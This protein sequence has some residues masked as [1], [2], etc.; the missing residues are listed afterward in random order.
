[1][2][3]ISSLKILHEPSNKYIANGSYG[4]SSQ[5]IGQQSTKAPS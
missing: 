2:F 3:T 4:E 1:M 5:A